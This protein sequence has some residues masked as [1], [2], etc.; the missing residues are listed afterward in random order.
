MKPRWYWLD[1]EVARSKERIELS[2]QALTRQY[3]LTQHG[4][5]RNFP[6]LK[7]ALQALGHQ[8]DML[9]RRI[10]PSC[11]TPPI[12]LFYRYGWTSHVYP[13]LFNWSGSIPRTGVS[14][15]KE[16]SGRSNFRLHLMPAMSLA[17]IRKPVYEIR[18][19]RSRRVECRHAVPVGFSRSQY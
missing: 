5:P 13:N 1:E 7:A 18:Y 15:P 2:Y 9:I 3:R 14:A 6:T 16:K 10:N 17:F 8:P 19:F 12:R 11:P 4:Q